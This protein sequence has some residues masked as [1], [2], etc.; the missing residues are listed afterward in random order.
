MKFLVSV[1]AFK[2]NSDQGPPT[3]WSR[4]FCQNFIKKEKLQLTY[5]VPEQLGNVTRLY[6]L[7]VMNR[8]QCENYTNL[9]PKTYFSR[10]F[11]SKTLLY[12]A[13]FINKKSI[14]CSASKSSMEDQKYFTLV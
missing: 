10:T 9:F 12:L 1:H 5:L 11:Q 14:P 3:S 4:E 7:A 6:E 2:G 13:I 8:F